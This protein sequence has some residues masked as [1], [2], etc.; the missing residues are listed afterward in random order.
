[1]SIQHRIVVIG[2]SGAGKSTLAQNIASQL[3]IP[4]IELDN[5]HW[6]PNW[7]EASRE[8]FRQSLES[9]LQASSWVVDGNYMKARDLIWSRAETIV[10]LDYSFIRIL[11]RVIKRTLRRY[12]RKETLWAGN[13][14]SLRRA[15]CSKDSIIW[16]TI[17]N[18]S[19]RRMGY[20]ALFKQPEYQR[21]RVVHCHKPSDADNFVLSLTR[22]GNQP[23][24]G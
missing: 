10:W 22:S 11:F 23:P 4:W 1:M 3:D 20:Q 2:T 16:W 17:S 6:R 13:R 14:E 5:L 9:A 12:F 19:R 21:L 7:M 18:F 8:E 15:L 24:K